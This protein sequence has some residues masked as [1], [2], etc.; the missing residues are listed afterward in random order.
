MHKKGI[1]LL[2]PQELTSHLGLLMC[3]EGSKVAPHKT[4]PYTVQDSNMAAAT[5]EQYV[6]NINT[7]ESAFD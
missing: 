5:K 6:I 1:N 7:G 3:D 4:M 2:P